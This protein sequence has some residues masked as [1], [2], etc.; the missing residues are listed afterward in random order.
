MT[1]GQN[2]S[3]ILTKDKS[4]ECK[5]KYDRRKCNSNQKQNIDKFQYKSKKKHDIYKKDYIW[6]HAT[7]SCENREYLTSILKIQ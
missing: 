3:K 5:C 1:T 2:E 6:S 7:C 4:C